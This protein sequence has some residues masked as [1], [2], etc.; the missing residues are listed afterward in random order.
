[1]IV[2]DGY[3]PAD[4]KTCKT[5]GLPYRVWVEVDPRTGHIHLPEEVRAIKAAARRRR[6]LAE[7]GTEELLWAL[8]HRE[9]MKN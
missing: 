7:M 3:M 8:A 9:V 6:T 2:V 5:L 4:A 1:M